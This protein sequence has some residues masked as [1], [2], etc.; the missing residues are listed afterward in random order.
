MGFNCESPRRPSSLPQ[1]SC[2]LYLIPGSS[3]PLLRLCLG[4]DNLLL[5]YVD[6]ARLWDVK[7]REFWRS[8]ANDKVT[9]LLKQGGW[10]ELYVNQAIPIY[11]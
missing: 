6:R 9:D 8:M 11:T 3:S 2:S 7:T 4:E 5:E 1:I 10:K